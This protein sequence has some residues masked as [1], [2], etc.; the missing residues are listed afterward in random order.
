MGLF[1]SA[2]LQLYTAVTIVV[3]IKNLTTAAAI[4]A[5]RASTNEHP[6]Y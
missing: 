4:T 5:V 2:T 6:Q 3:A 1:V